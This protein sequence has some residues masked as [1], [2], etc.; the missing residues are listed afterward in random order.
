[1]SVPAPPSQHGSAKPPRAV[2]VA[3]LAVLLVGA[4]AA[5]AAVAMAPASARTWTVA[6]ALVAWL[7]MAVAV[8]SSAL[9]LRRSGR[10]TTALAAE[11]A[12]LKAQLSQQSA[13]AAHLGNVTLPAL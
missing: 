10:S 4:A 12:Q 1:M 7:L 11:V 3:P 9:L 8:L 5:G 13:E 2:P 6:T